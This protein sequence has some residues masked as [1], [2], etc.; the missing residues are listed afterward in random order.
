MV[1]ADPQLGLETAAPERTATADPERTATADPERTATADPERTATAD[2][3]RTASA[4]PDRGATAAPPPPRPKPVRRRTRLARGPLTIGEPAADVAAQLPAA[5]P[6]RPD[7][8]ADGGDAF[9][10]TIRAASVRGLYKRH[11][12]GP[13]QDDLC[14][15]LHA[16]T[17]SVILAVA[18]GVSAAA[19]SD[20][21]AA[22]AVRHAAACVDRQLERGVVDLDW[23]E[24]FQHAAWAL[25]E[26]HRRAAGDA[27]AGVAASA[28]SLATTLTVAVL[29]RA[30]LPDGNGR[31]GASDT[32]ASGPDRFR[33]QAAAVGDSPAYLLAEG[34]F[35]AVLGDATCADDLLGGGTRALPSDATAIEQSTRTLESG[36]VLLI[37]S[38]GLALPLADGT[39]DVGQ[40]LARELANPPDIID[41]ARLLDFSRATYDDDR[42]LIAVWASHRT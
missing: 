1:E 25:V 29:S 6:Y 3:E 19:R 24:V 34:A 16:A 42:T 17:H 8:V 32:D 21:A 31:D 26:E 33:V 7:T 2:P 41:F 40:A 14:L 5:E 38:D 20:L 11:L 22:L 30:E 9:G 28:A 10:L 23:A 36:S 39:G 35:E 18:D 4:D 27:N 12:G 13:R 37:C 15:R